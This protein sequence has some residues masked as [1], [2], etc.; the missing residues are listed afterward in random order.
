MEDA[1]V[2]DLEAVSEYRPGEFLIST[3]RAR[4][5]LNLIGFTPVKASE[6]YMEVHQPKV[7]QAD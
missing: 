5:D 4:L 7:Y 3:D 6:M 1:L 2:L